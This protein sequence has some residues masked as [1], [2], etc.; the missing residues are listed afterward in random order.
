MVF[1]SILISIKTGALLKAVQAMSRPITFLVICLFWSSL[2]K[3]SSN[4]V[5]TFFVVWFSLNLNRSKKCTPLYL[6]TKKRSSLYL[7]CFFFKW[8]VFL[9]VL[10]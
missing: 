4:K 5:K 3:S 10:L 8:T 9:I 1:L 7:N 2:S 6:K